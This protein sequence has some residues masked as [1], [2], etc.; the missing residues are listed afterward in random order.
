MH[1]GLLQIGVLRPGRQGGALGVLQL[2][3][4]NGFAQYGGQIGR[5]RRGAVV[6]RLDA[7]RIDAAV[8][9]IA[10]V[11]QHLAGERFVQL[12]GRIGRGR[13][14]FGIGH[15][16]REAAGVV[17]LRAQALLIGIGQPAHGLARGGARAAGIVQPQRFGLRR[18]R[19]QGKQAGTEPSAPARGS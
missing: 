13:G 6:A 19:G 8:A 9:Q 12:R 4:R 5:G 11:G 10:Q 3:L 14:E 18:R 15:G 17:I 1:Q 7:R 2:A 16:G